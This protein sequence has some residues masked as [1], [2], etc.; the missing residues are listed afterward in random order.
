MHIAFHGK[1][2]YA[3]AP[4]RYVARTLPVLFVHRYDVGIGFVHLPDAWK[5]VCSSYYAQYI[6]RSTYVLV[7][8]DCANKDGRVYVIAAREI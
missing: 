7:F 4:Q 2:G 6:A 8:L 1:N 5:E 3:N